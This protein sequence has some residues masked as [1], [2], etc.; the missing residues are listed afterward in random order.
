[1]RKIL[2]ITML[3]IFLVSCSNDEDSGEIGIS[4]QPLTGILQGE[5]FTFVDG[6]SFDTITFDD[7]EALNINLTNVS[8]TCE[9]FIGDFD[10]RISFTV[11]VGVGVYTDINIVDIKNDETPFNNLDRTVEIT[12]LTET[13]VSGKLKLER[14]SNDIAEGS[15]FEGSFTV[16]ICQ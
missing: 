11:P 16:P 9:D 5:S 13:E 2:S 10:L 3:C 1:M 8:A 6:K 12:S 15:S 14:N 4:D 7:E